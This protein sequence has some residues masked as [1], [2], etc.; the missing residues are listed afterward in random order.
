MY[1]CGVVVLCCQKK[2]NKEGKKI[3]FIDFA[4]FANTSTFFHGQDLLAYVFVQS[5]YVWCF[6]PF[7]S[8]KNTLV[9]WFDQW[10]EVLVVVM[11]GER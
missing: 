5:F 4:H 1:V 6:F 11:V 9:V 10:S 2:I 8:N 3:F 7:H